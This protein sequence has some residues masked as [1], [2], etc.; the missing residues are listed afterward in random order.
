MDIESDGDDYANLST[1]F[2]PHKCSSDPLKITKVT[3]KDS[4][5]LFEIGTEPGKSIPAE[6]AAL[7]I[8]TQ[9]LKSI[10]KLSRKHQHS[11]I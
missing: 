11:H 7:G 2:N 10:L 5:G 3:V 1:A 9:L 6:S 4:S 8:L